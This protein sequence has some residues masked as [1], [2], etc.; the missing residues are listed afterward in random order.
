MDGNNRTVEEAAEDMGLTNIV[1][2]IRSFKSL[3]LVDDSASLASSPGSSMASPTASLS[4]AGSP[5][6]GTGTLA[7]SSN[8]RKRGG[9]G[10]RAPKMTRE[11]AKLKRRDY[12]RRKR[13]A[14]MNQGHGYEIEIEIL[15][16]EHDR[17]VSMLA[18]MKRERAELQNMLG[19]PDERSAQ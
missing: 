5:I 13:A 12:M 10:S 11:E 17:L 1:E 2:V 19:L 18:N 16:R 15:G 8:K 7:Q 14:D 9:G 4:D 3:S 6:E